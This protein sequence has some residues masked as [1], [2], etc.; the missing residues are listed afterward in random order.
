[1]FLKELKVLSYSIAVETQEILIELIIKNS[2]ST[3]LYIYN[4][5]I[6]LCYL[7]LKKKMIFKEFKIFEDFRY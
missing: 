3:I 2:K 5:F 1:M 6:K 4:G 7:Q